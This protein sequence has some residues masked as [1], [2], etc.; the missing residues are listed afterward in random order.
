MIEKIKLWAENYYILRFLKS[1][2]K[3]HIFKGKASDVKEF[4][5]EDIQISEVPANVMIWE[6]EQEEE[7]ISKSN[8]EGS[9]QYVKIDSSRAR[10][11][12]FKSEIEKKRDYGLAFEN[13]L[14][15]I[16]YM[17]EKKFWISGLS[18]EQ[19]E[20]IKEETDRLYNIY[21]IKFSFFSKY[22]MS[23]VTY[24]KECGFIR[25]P[26]DEIYIMC[27][28]YIASSYKRIA[29]LSDSKL[30]KRLYTDLTEAGKKVTLINS[31]KEV[32]SAWNTEHF[33]VVIST[34]LNDA[35]GDIE[36]KNGRSIFHLRFNNLFTI[37]SD[38]VPLDRDMAI[39]LIP[40][41]NKDGI[42]TILL[43]H[44]RSIDVP[45]RF[46]I[47]FDRFEDLFI[48]SNHRKNF[49]G[50]EIN[51]DGLKVLHLFNLKG[52]YIDYSDCKAFGAN[53]INGER[54]TVGSCYDSKPDI[55]FFGPCTIVGPY[56][57]DSTTIESYLQGLV[58]DNYHIHNMATHP[59]F[60]TMKMR[61]LKLKKGDFVV[62]MPYDVSVFDGAGAEIISLDECYLT[63]TKERI[64]YWWESTTHINWKMNKIIAEHLYRTMVPHLGNVNV[65]GAIRKCSFDVMNV[66]F[67][68]LFRKYNESFKEWYEGLNVTADTSKK[69]G[70]IVMNGN[71]V[72]EGH[73]FLICEAAKEVDQLYIFVLQEEKSYFDFKDRMAMVQLA[74][75]EISNVTVLPSGCFIISNGTMPG[76]F[77]KENLQEEKLD[78]STDLSLFCEVI[79]PLFSISVRF[80]GDEPEDKFTRQYNEQMKETLPLYGI[81]LKVFDRK[82]S[83]GVTISGTRVREFFREEQWDKMVGLVPDVIIN[84]LRELKSNMLINYN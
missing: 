73:R 9:V 79:A 62:Y 22:R 82:K 19:Q 11:F 58:K 8:L 54:L 74:C 45:K 72:T 32:N 1:F 34:D 57:S 46:R 68:H 48:D 78:A 56:C 55:Y 75:E 43:K 40:T 65:R 83:E 33:D 59:S 66:R 21:G 15:Y 77:D 30:S 63:N 28:R 69:N 6:C 49:L 35:V 3:G 52:K 41:W 53:R 70:C 39:N 76:Y 29:I 27:I 64:N 23:Y 16:Y 67:D 13:L 47:V 18:K 2:F 50:E 81:E 5:Y 51:Y 60:S 42:T 4:T 26:F 17:G 20:E 84:Y 25:F 24:C 36:K 7:A 80:V 71:P 61:T 14:H 38:N 12:Y 10:K 31:Y 37:Y 44:P